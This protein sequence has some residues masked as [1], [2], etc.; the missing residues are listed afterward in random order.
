MHSFE[1]PL[2]DQGLSYD[3]IQDWMSRLN[4]SQDIVSK[5][6]VKFGDQINFI[7][8][9][10]REEEKETELFLHQLQKGMALLIGRMSEVSKD[11]KAA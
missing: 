9:L 1:R 2:K 11:N 8:R 6:Q 5:A 7:D 10:Y 3:L 4:Q